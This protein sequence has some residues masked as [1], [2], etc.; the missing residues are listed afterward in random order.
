ML[1]FQKGS[2][3]PLGS[4]VSENGVNFAVYAPHARSV[5][6]CLFDD[7]GRCEQHRVEMHS[8]EGGV[9]SIFVE[10]LIEGA[11]YGYRTDGQYE[12]S[13][14]LFFNINKLLLDPYAKDFS[15]DFTWSERHY[16][17]LPVGEFNTLDNA[18]DMPKSKV[19]KTSQYS[20]T[21]PNIPWQNSFIYE[22]HV[23]GT[24]QLHP[25]IDNAKKGKFAALVDPQFLQHLKHLGVT[26]IELLPVH[27][28]VSEQFLT[29]KGLQNYWGYN[30]LSFFVPHKAYCVGGNV[31][32][33]TDMVKQLHDNNIEVIIDV[34]Y[35]HTAE[36]GVDGPMLSFKGLHNN[37][38]YRTLSSPESVYIN[39]TGC[40]N[41]I[42][43]DDPI[44]LKLVMDSLRYWVEVMGVDG[45]RFD[46]ATILAR[47]ADG[48]SSRHSFFQT[49]H[50]D[51]ILSTVKLIAEPW[52]VGPGG[53][54]LGAFP[55]PWREWNDKYRDVVRRFWRGDSGTLPELAK[56]IHGS[57]DLFEHNQ[58]GPLN[59]INFLTSHDGYSLSDWVSYER[60]H[61]EANGEG[62]RDGHSENYSFNCGHEGETVDPE[63]LASRY[64]MQVNALVTLLMSKGVPMIAAGTELNHSQQ[65][66]NN[67][68]CQDNEVSWLNWSNV[69]SQQTLIE[70]IAQ[71]IKLRNKLSVFEHPFFVHAA[72][73]R[74]SVKWLNKESQD[75]SE[76]DWHDEDNKT[77]MYVLA[78]KLKSNAVMVILNADTEHFTITLPP[79]PFSSCWECVFSSEPQSERNVLPISIC[80]TAQSAWVLVSNL[81]EN[82]NG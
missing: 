28:F 46:L 37:G 68:Y 61:N 16:C 40:G 7:A 24:T 66:N 23:K 4:T 44:T 25:A 64:K 22:C 9:W 8:H 3:L 27:A 53:Y 41:T 51:P 76:S 17:H 74:F 75:M 73:E 81:E 14:G 1:S 49:I 70:P 12:L 5:L 32:E 65:G 6:L 58:R 50:Q 69:G 82:T 52:D 79:P 54:Q 42:N 78:D 48:F 20:G 71:L 45:F 62:N 57:N 33:F 59:S 60:K 39:D 15:G 36:G 31:T 80:L 21:K 18:I 67:A 34:V 55:A 47:T 13:S 29:T 30:T 63:I 19:V 56:R 35:N 10:S 2:M 43:I 38:Y 72:D 77:L 11:L 26:A